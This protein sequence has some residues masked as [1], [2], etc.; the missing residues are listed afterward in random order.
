MSDHPGAVNETAIREH[1]I[2]Q[3]AACEAMG[4][5]FTGR[6]CRVLSKIL[7]RNTMTGRRVL[8][9]PGSARDGA[10]ALRLC[11]G[12]HALMLSRTDRALADVYPPNEADDEAIAEAVSATIVRHD[13]TLSHAL[14]SAP[15]TNEIGRSGMLL[16]GFLTIARET[17]LPFALYEIG[18]SAGLNLLFDQFQYR[19]GD[20]EWGD[21]DSPARL[22]PEVRGS[23]PPLD[24]SVEILLRSGCDIQPIDVGKDADRLRL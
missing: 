1:F 8:D 6:L 15:Q 19:Y 22:R 2:H 16:P 23:I 24:G 13:E 7:D 11:G 4:S 9:W 18:S 20:F 21:R 5:P 17:G 10:L 3:A 12:L 14:Q